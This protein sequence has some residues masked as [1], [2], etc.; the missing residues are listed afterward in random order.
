MAVLTA[1][2]PTSGA[3]S[4][5]LALSLLDF[6]GWST[7]LHSITQ[8]GHF[9]AEF[10]SA[11]GGT[12]TFYSKKNLSDGFT[13]TDAFANATGVTAAP[14][15]VALSQSNASGVSGVV[16]VMGSS[17]IVRGLL[18]FADE[19][20]V[21]HYLH[22]LTSALD[23]NSEFEEQ[24][25]FEEVLKRTMRMLMERIRGRIRGR[26]DYK[27]NNN[28]DLLDLRRPG[29]FRDIHAKM[30]AEVITRQVGTPDSLAY[31]EYADT[32]KKSYESDINSMS[33]EIDRDQ[34][35]EVDNRTR[36]KAR[37]LRRA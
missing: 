32:L 5:D 27:N 37:R 14:N 33:I 4:G 30:T 9:F 25:R 34:N 36:V 17:G 8:D 13:A 2:H 11:G 20:D 19:S 29:Q 10:V 6:S 18:S 12:L 26:A 28:P 21:R 16:S 31:S 23:T 1:N 3:D 15:D 7:S 35:S 22:E 24:V